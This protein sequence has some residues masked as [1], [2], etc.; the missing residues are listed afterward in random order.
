MTFGA[1]TVGVGDS[2]SINLINN[3]SAATMSRSDINVSTSN[4][5]FGADAAATGK[6]P[7]LGNK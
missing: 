3:G 6:L 2:G 7:N 5:T 4:I 1:E